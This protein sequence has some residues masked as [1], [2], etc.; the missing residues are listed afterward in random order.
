MRALRHAYKINLR[1][2]RLADAVSQRGL[3]GYHRSSPA[4]GHWTTSTVNT[5][6]KLWSS[7][8]TVTKPALTEEED[9]D[10]EDMPSL[11]TLETP[12][13]ATQPHL[14]GSASP[15]TADDSIESYLKA[16]NIKSRPV[17]N[18]NWNPN[19]PL[20]WTQ[21]FGR[22]SEAERARL[23]E[24]ACLRPGDEGYFDV[25][26]TTVDCVTIVRT[27]EQ[28]RKV[29]A[30]L[31]TAPK[32]VFHACDTEVMAIDL[33][34]VGPVGNGYVTCVSVYSGPD[35]DYGLGDGP[36]TCLWIDNLD[37]SFGIL[38]I[39]K[40][41]FE[42]EEQLKV[43]HNYGFDRH[44]MWNHGINVMGFGGDTMHM[45]RL[46]DTSR[47]RSSIGPGTGY[48]LE[49]LTEELLKV[50]KT[51]MKE[52]FGVKR[53]RKDG[54]EGSLVDI[55][56]VEVI[57]RDP[58][59]RERWIQYSSYDAKGTWK[60][61]E[62]LAAA[63]KRKPW[64][65]N[66][67]L[68]DYYM[69]HM[70]PFGEV[71]TDMERRGIRV[72]ARDYLAKVEVQAREDRA[73]HSRVF[74]EWAAKQIGPDGWAL[75]TGS[76]I[77]LQTFLFGG[78]KNSKTGEPTEAVRVFKVPTEELP[79]EA[80]EA[81]RLIDEEVSKKD[82]K[83]KWDGCEGDAILAT[84][85]FILTYM[86]PAEIEKEGTDE[87]N[88]MKVAQLKTLCKERGLKVSGKKAELQERLREHFLNVSQSP[89]PDM[90][91]FDTMSDEDLADA[92]KARGLSF[93]GSRREL[94]ERI[95]SDIEYI[96]GL[97]NEKAPRNSDG[98]VA[99]SE[100]LEVAAKRE[101]GAL[102]GMLDDFKLK[103]KKT[104][105]YKDVTITSLGKLEP[106]TFT[107]NGAPSVTANVLKRLAGDPFADPP[108]Y[109]TV[110]IASCL[111]NW[112]QWNILLIAS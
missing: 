26:D 9:H 3:C 14:N 112:V 25:S 80:Q 47:S 82:K 41:W 106:D 17:P 98:Y 61:R 97:L 39:F 29:L 5:N 111:S 103:S 33:S 44:V 24:L 96:G 1:Q 83:S 27:E 57:Q 85:V 63:L 67:N 89:E 53:L 6:G 55:P 68:L 12:Q 20:G 101:G 77:Q 22:Q 92:A 18:G 84:S 8:S 75:N 32:G 90:D 48:S 74:R 58:K 10:A 45:A 19:D 100:A 38:D 109:G 40:P 30:K 71:L 70:R 34:T 73:H 76:S 28:A 50:R 93:Q 54:T 64:F 31:Q 99:I 66:Y 94:L 86:F 88:Q 16:L 15:K 65:E 36:G 4:A 72:D 56:P 51:P 91:E 11:T 21:D 23:R 49:A 108:K 59:H 95:R 7:F 102:S 87:L 43:W 60:V 81:Y 110:S 107:G 79:E 35:F 2:R 46:Q 104:P 37:D 62:A 42:N 69:E 105:K 13:V 52:I 78:S